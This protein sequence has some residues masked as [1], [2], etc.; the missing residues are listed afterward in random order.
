MKIEE[1]ES[2]KMIRRIRQ[3]Q[4][5]ETKDMTDEEQIEYDRKKSEEF[6]KKY[7]LNLKVVSRSRK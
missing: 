5:E 3:K 4:Y 6:M 1:P 2:M 7:G